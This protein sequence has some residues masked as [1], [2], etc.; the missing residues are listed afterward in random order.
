MRSP[1]AGKLNKRIRIVKQVSTGTNSFGEQIS[2]S[3]DKLRRWAS[4]EPL[5]AREAIL[6][7]SNGL[8]VTH[9]VILRYTPLL[10]AADQI[11]F[12]GR[13]FDISSMMNIEEANVELQLLCHERKQ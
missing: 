1:P 4:I 8:E 5:N 3:D 10:S 2:E 6:A 13:T 7:A 11:E 12:Q 9:K